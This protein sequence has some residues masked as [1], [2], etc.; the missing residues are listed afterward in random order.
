M[1][2]RRNNTRKVHSGRVFDFH[3]D[4]V[5]LENGVTVDLEVIRHP[6]AAAI[7]PL[8]AQGGILLIRQFRYALDQDIWEIPAG[9]LNPGESPLDC[10]RRE[11]EEEAGVSAGDW[12]SLG[13]IMPLPGYSDEIIHLFMARRLTAARQHLDADELLEVREVAFETALTMIGS[14]TVRD[15]KTIAGLLLAARVLQSV[16]SGG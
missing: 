16:G 3:V 2:A 15:A 8:T 1:R 4:N 10:A 7:V 9:T 12:S 6:G 13:E 5:T 11:L 14:N